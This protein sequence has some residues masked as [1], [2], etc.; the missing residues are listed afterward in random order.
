M[1]T[2]NLAD[3]PLSTTTDFLI[4]IIEHKIGNW[5]ALFKFISCDE[6]WHLRETIPF[7]CSDK[8]S[9]LILLRWS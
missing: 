5:E 4:W 7:E 8:E 9:T 3:L 1:N 2:I 6:S